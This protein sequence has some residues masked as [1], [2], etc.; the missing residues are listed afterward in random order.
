MKFAITYFLT[1]THHVYTNTGQALI[2]AQGSVIAAESAGKD[3]WTTS[4]LTFDRVDRTP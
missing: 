1:I 3:R 4:V 2:T